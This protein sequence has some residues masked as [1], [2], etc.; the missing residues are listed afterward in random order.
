MAGPRN[1]LITGGTS[2]IGLALADRLSNKHRILVTGRTC[3]PALDVLI[4]ERPDVEFLSLDQSDP[5]QIASALQQKLD[6]KGWQHIDNAVLNAGVGFVT[7]PVAET[8][9]AIRQ[10]LRVNLAA[11]IAI[12]HFLYPYLSKNMG[13]LSLIGSTARKGAPDFASYAASKAALHGLARGLK[14]EWRSKVWVQA[15]HPGPTKTDMHQKAG[16]KL[17]L[18]RMVFIDP[19]SMAQMIEHAMARHKFS[20]NLGLANY[21]GGGQ[22][23][24]KGLQ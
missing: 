19:K 3:T 12:A 14:E 20:A 17:G 23:F 15:L 13:M 18:V 7:D 10:T 16:L 11:N 8:A 22:F 21:W 9:T 5:T 1:I 6:E 24:G 4:G 2:G